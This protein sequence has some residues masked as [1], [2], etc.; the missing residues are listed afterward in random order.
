MNLIF[1]NKN[2]FVSLLFFQILDPCRFPGVIGAVDGTHV[3]IWPPEKE[4][5]HLYINRKLYHSLN[6]LIVSIIN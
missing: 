1:K 6:V 4:R 2:K 5:E 3:A